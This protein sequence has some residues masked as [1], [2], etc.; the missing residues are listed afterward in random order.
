MEDQRFDEL[1]LQEEKLVQSV[2]QE[3][4]KKRPLTF[5]QKNR[6]QLLHLYWNIPYG[7]RNY[8]EDFFTGR[9]FRWFIQRRKWGG[10]DEREL[11]DLDFP[12]IRFIYPRLKKF[13]EMKKHAWPGEGNGHPTPEDW[14]KALDKMVEAF[15]YL[16]LDGEDIDAE[17][18]FESDFG[19]KIKNEE[20]WNK[21]TEELDRRSKIIE[22]GFGLFST[23]FFN[24]WD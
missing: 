8:L 11:W 17:G 14:Q 5:F 19:I 1:M 4:R 3:E 18:V 12:I 15:H 6:K 7:L 23:N 9:R 10:F 13:A 24:L 2:L 20:K 21:Y 16:I 22:E